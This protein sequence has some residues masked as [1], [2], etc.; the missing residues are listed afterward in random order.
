MKVREAVDD[1]HHVPV[2]LIKLHF[3]QPVP[4]STEKSAHV[5]WL[6]APT[7]E[8]YTFE[9]DLSAGQWERHSRFF[10]YSVRWS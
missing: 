5:A 4:G 6:D 7:D 8:T 9:V 1:Q 2:D 3:D 10:C